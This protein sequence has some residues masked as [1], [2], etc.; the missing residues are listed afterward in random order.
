[1][2]QFF[3]WWGA[4][5]KAMIPRSRRSGTRSARRSL[6]L[7][8]DSGGVNVGFED[9]RARQSFGRFE[10]STVAPG[11]G[12]TYGG[13]SERDELRALTAPL[14]AA[15]TPVLVRVSPEL[16][17]SRTVKLPAAAAE[18]LRE[19][20]GFEMERL[21]PF[22]TTDV[23]YQQAI[24]AENR[25]SHEIE[26]ELSLAQRRDV[27][28]AVGM[29]PEWQLEQSTLVD[30]DDTAQAPGD[31]LAL[32][33]RSARYQQR[34]WSGLNVLLLGVNV[35]LLAIVVVLPLMSQSKQLARLDDEIDRA[36]MRAEVASRIEAE[37]ETIRAGAQ[38]LSAH[39]Q[40]RLSSVTIIEDLSA[41]LPDATWL[42]RLEIK[43]G[44]LRLQGTSSSAS[45]LIGILEDAPRFM[46]AR[47]NSPVVREGNSGQERF[48]LSASIRRTT[49]A[50]D[51]FLGEDQESAG[52]LAPGLDETLP[53]SLPDDLPQELREA[54]NE[55]LPYGLPEG[56]LPRDPVP[57]PT[58][59]APAPAGTQ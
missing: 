10:R 57:A 51:D 24:R 49:A 44:G 19:V 8:I 18:N 36:R 13:A 53:E 11:G 32:G 27:D 14:G 47:F 6:I 3:S 21:T 31:A 30:G 23:Y 28:A 7:D 34:S 59:S 38:F 40:S 37:L 1:M 2:K 43:N 41:L 12:L 46:G 39:A 48:N 33:F 35:L 54:I 4:E 22:R 9:G 50:T 17:L 52:A 29:L 45:T 20:L 25:Q 42:F 56:E 26:V 5:L 58:A 15:R 55:E 16:T